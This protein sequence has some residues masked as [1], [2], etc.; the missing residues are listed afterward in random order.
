MAKQG[1]LIV[2]SGPS[3]VGKSTVR[4]ELFKRKALDFRYSISMTTRKPRPGEKNG[5]DYFF[6]TK[7]QFRKRIQKGQMLEYAQYVDNYYGTPLP[8]V[9]KM[10]NAGHNVFLEIEV[11]GAMKVKKKCPQALFIFLGPPSWPALKERLIGRKTDSMPVINKR[12]RRATQELKMIPHY[13]YLVLNDHIK[14]AADRIET[15]IKGEQFR[16]SR[17]MSNYLKKLGD[18]KSC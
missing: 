4:Q 12:I 13:D 10:L 11:Q 18:Y 17:V 16:T 7:D 6:V 2:M 14:S 8:Y 3:G 9:Q 15:I 1:M 5:R